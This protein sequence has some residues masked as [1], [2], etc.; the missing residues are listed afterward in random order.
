MDPRLGLLIL[1]A[2]ATCS[3]RFQCGQIL[4][5]ILDTQL[6]RR[7]VPRFPPRLARLPTARLLPRHNLNTR[8]QIVR[9]HNT[10]RAAVTPP[11]ADMLRMV[12]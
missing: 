2:A 3:W 10:L 1:L 9:T 5:Y 6:T 8:K 12:T 7:P 11:A 4:C